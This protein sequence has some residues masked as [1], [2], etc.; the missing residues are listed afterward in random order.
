M[1]TLISVIISYIIR[2]RGQISLALPTNVSLIYSIGEYLKVY[3]L[4]DVF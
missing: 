4:C 2:P 3:P 1:I